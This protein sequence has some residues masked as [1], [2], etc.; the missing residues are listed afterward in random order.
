MV[1]GGKA[2][3][4]QAVMT[5]PGKIEMREVPAPEAGKGQVLVKIKRIGVCGSDIH[6]YHGQH[7]YTRYPV[8]QCHVV[9]GQVLAIG[10]DVS[11]IKEGDRVTI[12]PQVVCGKCFACRHNQYH[13]CDELKVMGF[14]TTGA[15]SEFFAV[16]AERVLTL[17][18]KIAY[19]QG[20]MVE[21]LAVGVH[22]LQRGGEIRGKKILIL[23]AG[24][25]GNLTAQAAKGLGAESVMITDISAYRLDIAA[26]CGIDHCINTATDDLGARIADAFGPDRADLTLECVGINETMD[27]A[28]RYA[29]KG[30]DIIVVGVFPEKATVD[31]GLVQD[32]ELRL[33]GTLMYQKSDFLVAIELIESGK[34]RFKPLI[35]NHFNFRDYANAYEFIE[36]NRDKCLKVIIK[37]IGDESI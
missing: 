37:G 30:T 15:A 33:I 36:I 13:I 8:V 24:P 34:I 32:R 12:Q 9:A 16:D 18:E 3:M 28:V 26:E 35:S 1:T 25:I 21:P 23:G 14:Q 22:A 5:A 19:D 31:L 27:Q 20:A 17:S 2:K 4:L 29:R 6:V 7:P 11:G 10:P